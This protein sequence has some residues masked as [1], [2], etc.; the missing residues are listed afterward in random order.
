MAEVRVTN[1]VRNTSSAE[2]VGMTIDGLLEEVQGYFH[3]SGE[4]VANVR[5][6]GS[7]SFVPVDSDYVLQSGDEVR[8][9]R[10]AG[11][12]GRR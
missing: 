11:T 6:S 9:V 8:F 12:K 2:F 10:A 5:N 1:G 3:L 4:E 7:S